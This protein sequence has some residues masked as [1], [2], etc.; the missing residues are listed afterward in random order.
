MA[1][2]V[3]GLIKNP[4]DLSTDYHLCCL[5]GVRSLKVDWSYC[6]DCRKIKEKEY[7]YKN[8]LELEKRY[9]KLKKNL[10]RNGKLR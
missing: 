8:Y 10:I 3:A 4:S 1:L 6:S 5:C 2:C 7:K 9:F